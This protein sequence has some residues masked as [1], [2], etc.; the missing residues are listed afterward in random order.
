MRAKEAEDKVKAL[1]ERRNM[2][3]DKTKM[4]L[5]K[6]DTAPERFAQTERKKSGGGRGQFLAHSHIRNQC[7]IH[8][9]C[10][11]F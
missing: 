9:E 3:R 11:I 2:Y 7:P 10:S 8:K 5:E 6:I 4:V 1:E